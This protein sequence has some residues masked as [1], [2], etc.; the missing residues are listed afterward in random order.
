MAPE[1]DEEGQNGVPQT[2]EDQSLLHAQHAYDGPE[3]SLTES[4]DLHVRSPIPSDAEEDGHLP[5][6]VWMRESSKSFRWRWIPLPLRKSARNISYYAGVVNKWSYG[7]EEAQI[8]RIEPFFPLVQE[9]PLWLVERF[10]P[11]RPHK[12]GALLVLYLAWLMTFCL[13]IRESASSGNIEGYG[14]PNP[15]WCGANFWCVPHSFIF[16]DVLADSYQGLR[17][18]IAD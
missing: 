7:P 2:S 1:N 9:A 11:K 15:I 3:P 8:Q 17:V 10:L 5:L 6:P 4:N 13:I 12:I 18:T 16:E 14:V